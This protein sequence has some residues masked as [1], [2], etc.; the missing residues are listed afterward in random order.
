MGPLVLLGQE[1]VTGATVTTETPAVT[2]ATGVMVP[3]VSLALR[4]MMA[5]L[6]VTAPNPRKLPSLQ[7]T[8]T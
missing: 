6:D 8:K 5:R 1:V 7:T 4:V 2:G 3:T